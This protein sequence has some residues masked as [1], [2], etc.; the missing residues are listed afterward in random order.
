[1]PA[2]LRLGTEETVLA[3]SR[4]FS[5]VTCSKMSISGGEPLLR[6]DLPEIL[7]FVRT[8]SVPMVLTTNGRLLDKQ[9][10]RTLGELGVGTFQIPLH[11][12]DQD[13]H[14][15]LSGG[16]SWNSSIRCLVDLR[17][18]GLSVVPVFVATRINLNR[19]PGVIEVC[20]LL[21]LKELIFNRF[22]PTGLGTLNRNVIGVPSEE[23]LVA[24]LLNA[25]ELA[26]EKD[27]TIHLGMPIAVPQQLR[28]SLNHV[29]FASC[30]IS[31]GQSRFTVDSAANIR[32]CNQSGS[33][34]GN[35]LHGGA[36]ALAHRLRESAGME[37]GEYRA[38]QILQ[39]ESLVGISMGQVPALH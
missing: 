5:V 33:S 35:L 17:A 3:L 18:A 11:A 8:H 23:E 15:F 29:T 10:A 32:C 2:P 4:L 21:G 28:A 39:R 38:C 12:A 16:D 36:E 9:K 19:L 37:G 20:A 24:Q 6:P 31:R 7:R 34:I 1:M 13:T 27:V 30:P 14:N 25:N 26:G 22:V